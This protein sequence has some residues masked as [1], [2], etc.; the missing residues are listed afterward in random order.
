MDMATLQLF[1]NKFRY[2]KYTGTITSYGTSMDCTPV[3]IGLRGGTLR[4]KGDMTDF[5]SCNYLSIVR[6]GKTLYG[7]ID[8][9]K[10]LNDSVF[11]GR[12]PWTP[13]GRLKGKLI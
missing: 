7:W 2:P 9:V 4:V 11:E 8:D 6:D 1:Q 13:G 5:M 12:I 10:V 3:G